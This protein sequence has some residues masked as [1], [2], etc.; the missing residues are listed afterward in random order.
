MKQRRNHP[1][2]YHLETA[3]WSDEISP[4]DKRG[5]K[6]E[7]N[8]FSVEFEKLSGG[9]GTGPVRFNPDVAVKIAEMILRHHA[10][11]LLSDSEI[12][13]LIEVESNHG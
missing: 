13:H 10:P 5:L 6:V 9:H 1:K 4:Y 7:I 2:D 3:S 8:K 12:Y 11:E